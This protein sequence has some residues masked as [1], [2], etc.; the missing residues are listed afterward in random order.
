MKAS[1]IRLSGACETSQELSAVAWTIGS[2]TIYR[3]GPS[4]VDEELTLTVTQRPAGLDDRRGIV[5]LH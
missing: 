3:R 5:R 4:R 1:R 2:R